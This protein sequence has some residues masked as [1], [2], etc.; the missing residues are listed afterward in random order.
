MSDGALSPRGAS[1]RP[2]SPEPFKDK[3]KP[4]KK[5]KETIKGVFKTEK[6]KR[7]KSKKKATAHV[8][9]LMDFLVQN[10]MYLVY[11]C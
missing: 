9:L 6:K 1:S 10:C 4:K 5:M 11:F 7:D 3:N 8:K 2:L